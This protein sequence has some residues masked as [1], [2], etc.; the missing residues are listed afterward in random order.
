MTVY[1]I[2]QMICIYF[3][4]GCI[5]AKICCKADFKFEKC[6]FGIILIHPIVVLWAI[7]KEIKLTIKTMKE[8]KEKK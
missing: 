7:C 5:V 8:I 2:L 4:S 3:M 6:C 1:V